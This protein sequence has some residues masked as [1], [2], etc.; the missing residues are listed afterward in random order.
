MP[1]VES[2][3]VLRQRLDALQQELAAARQEVDR[4]RQ[5]QAPASAR[6]GRSFEDVGVRFYSQHVGK[7]WLGLLL[8]AATVVAVQERLI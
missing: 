6:R 3:A 4:L 7:V 1:D 5:A 2:P 8:V